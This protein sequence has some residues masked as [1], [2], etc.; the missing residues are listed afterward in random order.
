M[1]LLD[2]D[3]TVREIIYEGTITQLHR[4]LKEINFASFHTAAIEKVATGLTTVEEVLR[5]VPRS[6]LYGKSLGQDRT[7]KL[8]PVSASEI[9]N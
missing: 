7:A 3:D 4:Y 1:E 8:K 6:A 2:I 5:V 9:R